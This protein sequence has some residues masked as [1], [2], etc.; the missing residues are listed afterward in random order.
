MVRTIEIGQLHA[1]ECSE[2]Q[3]QRGE[4]LGVRVSPLLLIFGQFS[5]FINNPLIWGSEQSLGVEWQYCGLS[6]PFS[7][8]SGWLYSE[9][10]AC[11]TFQPG[12]WDK[13]TLRA[14]CA[15]S[16]AHSG[17]N[18][19][20]QRVLQ[21][22]PATP[23]SL[24]LMSRSSA[25]PTGNWN[26]GKRTDLKELESGEGTGMKMSKDGLKLS[27]SSLAAH[28]QNSSETPNLM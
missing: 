11:S 7:T 24:V 2:G 10:A 28:G 9:N 26:K 16:Q 19:L 21:K 22:E 14:P 4:M 6:A 20:P 27:V 23:S 13:G 1:R 18:T 3:G 12:H 25:Q 15:P 8:G 17:L 5:L